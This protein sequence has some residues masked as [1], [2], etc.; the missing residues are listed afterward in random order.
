MSPNSIVKATAT[1][2]T[3]EGKDKNLPRRNQPSPLGF[4]GKIS[5][6]GMTKSPPHWGSQVKKFKA[7]LLQQLFQIGK[8][9]AN[10][11][12]HVGMELERNSLST[13]ETVLVYQYSRQNDLQIR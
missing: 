1:R 5:P 7:A 9:V 11:K 3:A 10:V 12:E 2:Q 8:G 6:K 4:L 13:T